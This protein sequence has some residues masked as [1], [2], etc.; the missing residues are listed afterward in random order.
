MYKK[1]DEL[2]IAVEIAK[3]AG[4]VLLQ[5][6]NKELVVSSKEN[7]TPVTDADIA[8]DHLIIKRL[9]ENF[10]YSILTEE[11]ADDKNR[12]V[13]EFVWIVDP[14]DGT[15]DFIDKN[16]EFTVAIGLVRN[17]EV[18]LGVVYRPTTKELYFAEKGKGAYKEVNGEEKRIMVSGVKSI[19]EAKFLVSKSD[20][21]NYDFM[22]KIGAIN[23]TR[24]GSSALRICKVAEGEY[25]GYF[26]LR[27][28]V[29]EWDDCAPKI[30]LT[31]AGG[32]LTN[33]FG[34]SLLYNQEDVSRIKGIMAN[35]GLLHKELI[36][37]IQPFAKDE[38][39]DFVLN[40]R[41]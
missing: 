37:K 9:K 35:N 26:V 8:V 14:L 36:E 27:S 33:V 6:Y 3:E 12:L 11:S 39:P 34:D 16:G 19:S 23:R 29:F 18:I 41:I 5:Y 22:D 7:N 32:I 40:L 4:D 30:I 15:K 38:Y 25:D 28:R 10:S 17:S 24:V 21:R 1:S 20:A 2:K 13:S 31:E